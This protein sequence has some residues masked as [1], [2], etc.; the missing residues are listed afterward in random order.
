MAVEEHTV[1][2]TVMNEAGLGGDPVVVGELLVAVRGHGVRVVDVVI[3][4]L[5]AATATA[6]LIGTT[7]WKAHGQHVGVL[8]PASSRAPFQDPHRFRR[9]LGRERLQRA[10]AAAVLHEQVQH[11]L[12]LP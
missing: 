2:A 11:C 6:L 4:V 7:S 8:A 3:V 10:V 12:T 9:D 5:S 1:V